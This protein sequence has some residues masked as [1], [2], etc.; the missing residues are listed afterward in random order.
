MTHYDMIFDEVSKKN[1]D[2]HEVSKDN[3]DHQII[4]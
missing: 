4:T 3:T 2:H 1:M